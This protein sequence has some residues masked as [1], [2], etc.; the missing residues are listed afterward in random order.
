MVDIHCHI[1]PRI[2]DGAQS[3]A[4]SIAMARMARL[5]GVD[6]LAAMPHFNGTAESLEMLPGIMS[7][8]LYHSPERTVFHGGLY[9]CVTV[10]FFSAKGN[11]NASGFNVPGVGTDV[12]YLDIRNFSIRFCADS[13]GYLFKF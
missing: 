12:A 10:E 5:S 1:L 7:R 13:L 9:E 6:K 8:V 3:M 4:E 11:K 2:D